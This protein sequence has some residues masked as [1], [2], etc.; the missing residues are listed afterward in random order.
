MCIVIW[1]ICFL[2]SDGSA[3]PSMPQV[4]NV[5]WLVYESS[6]KKQRNAALTSMDDDLYF[7][8]NDYTESANSPYPS[9][10]NY[11]EALTEHPSR[12]G[13]SKNHS[14]TNATAYTKESSAQQV[15]KKSVKP[16]INKEFSKEYYNFIA[17]QSQVVHHSL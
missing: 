10:I 14:I 3:E 13:K 11:S 5:Y 9:A 17:I 15:T 1:C 2:A 6:S 12:L 7:E 16:A 4:E 8:A